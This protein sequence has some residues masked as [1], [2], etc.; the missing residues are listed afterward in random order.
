V[1]QIWSLPMAMMTAELA[2]AM[3]SH[4]GFILWGRQAWGPIIPFVDGWMYAP[5][6]AR[7]H[8]TSPIVHCIR[9]Q[10]CER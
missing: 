4:S 5:A 10:A 9:A 3:P 2:S 7:T 6:P 1:P 8:N